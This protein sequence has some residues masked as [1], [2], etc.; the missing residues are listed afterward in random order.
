MHDHGVLKF[1]V[2][3]P[4]MRPRYAN[5]REVI[6]L[7]TTRLMGRVKA[8]AASGRGVDGPMPASKDGSTYRDS[9]TLIASIASVVRERR[10][11]AGT[12]F[13][14]VVRPFGARPPSEDAATRARKRGARQR[15]AQLRA[16]AVIGGFLQHAN[17]PDSVLG[18]K[19]RG[20]GIRL[21]RI[22]SRTVVDNASLAAI[23]SVPAKDKRA[24]GRGV[25]RP[26]GAREDEQEEIAAIAR[27]TLVVE[28]VEV[29]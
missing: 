15:Q 13:E 11:K 3:V 17:A 10:T 24:A 1:H 27:A 28:L 6:G 4:E 26:F 19:R 14:G 21:S 12:S 22:R 29:G 2:E 18:R 25:Y 9:G 23:L 20:T 8:R 5:E 16:A 7:M